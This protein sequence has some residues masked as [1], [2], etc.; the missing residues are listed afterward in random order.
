M[1]RVR[2]RY[3]K[4][5]G[6]YRDKPVATI[7]AYIE[8]VTFGVFLGLGGIYIAREPSVVFSTCPYCA[9]GAGWVAILLAFFY[10]TWVAWG[11]YCMLLGV[12]GNTKWS[13]VVGIL[14]S[15]LTIFLFVATMSA[16]VAT[17]AANTSP[18]DCSKFER[19]N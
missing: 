5:I 9:F 17:N 14:L 6:S 13:H 1:K 18:K 15:V 7:S 10:I 11:G 3:K 12:R 8:R 4:M 16:S 19:D 2:K